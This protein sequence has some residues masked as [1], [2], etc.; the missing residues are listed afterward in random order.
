LFL[1]LVSMF[2]VFNYNMIGGSMEE[3]TAPVQ[4]YVSH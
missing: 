1:T 4:N 3:S 2:C